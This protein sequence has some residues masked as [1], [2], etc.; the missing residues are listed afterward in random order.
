MYFLRI[1]IKAHG[2]LS[3]A[4][5]EERNELCLVCE[6]ITQPSRSRE[7]LAGRFVTRQE[8]PLRRRN[9]HKATTHN[10]IY[11]L[12]SIKSQT[13]CLD[14]P[15]SYVMHSERAAFMV[16]RRQRE[17]RITLI[18]ALA[19][20]IIKSYHHPYFASI[21]FLHLHSSENTEKWEVFCRPTLCR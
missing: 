17:A 10:P 19:A 4:L 2:L 20:E 18:I 3:V 11:T 14:C 16:I 6:R 7:I 5:T 13:T 1:T 15:L 21:R 12:V 9:E 8:C